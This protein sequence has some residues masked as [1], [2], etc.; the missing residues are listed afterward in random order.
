MKNGTDRSRTMMIAGAS[1]VALIAY[2]GV[3]TNGRAEDA[4]ANKPLRVVVHV[5]FADP[6]RHDGGLKNIANI[7]KDVAGDPGTEIEVVCHSAGIG[8]VVKKESKYPEEVAGLIK[9]GVRFKAC[10]NTMRQRNL[11]QE[12]L[13]PNI[14]TVPSGAVEVIRKQQAGFA[15]F[16]P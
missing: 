11:K 15:Y 1:A 13:L 3:R 8:L 16:K 9:K 2:L 7:L 12:D 10:R 14:D 6:A 5:N 4:A